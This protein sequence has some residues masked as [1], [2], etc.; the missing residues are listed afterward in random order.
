MSPS[1]SRSYLIQEKQQRDAST[2]LHVIIVGAGLGG[3]GAAIS[4]LLAGHD[5]T[6]LEAATADCKRHSAKTL[7]SCVKAEI[8]FY[9]YPTT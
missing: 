3:L 6:V 5:V 9:G 8:V 4:T 1:T 7:F 2:K